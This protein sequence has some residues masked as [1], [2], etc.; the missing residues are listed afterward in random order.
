MSGQESNSD[1]TACISCI[2]GSTFRST[3]SQSNCQICPANSACVS[4]GF[5]C[6]SGYEP[7]GDGAGCVLCGEGFFKS[8]AGNSPC[9]QCSTGQESAANRESCIACGTGKYRPLS[10]FNKCIPCP[11]NGICNALSLTKCANGWKIISDGDGCEQCPVGQDSRDGLTCQ[12][13]PFGYFKPDQA[14]QTCIS[15]P[16]GSKSCFDSSVSCNVGYYYDFGAQCKINETYFALLQAG[17]TA[18]LHTLTVTKTV[19]TILPAVTVIKS[20]TKSQETVT[21]SFNNIVETVTLA[22]PAGSVALDYVG[23]LP[24]SPLLFGAVC[25]VGGS[26]ITFIITLVFCRKSPYRSKY[27]YFDG[28]HGTVTTDI[29]FSFCSIILV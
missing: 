4:T 27:E 14:Y 19:T 26:F 8:A 12:Q 13:C 16:Q 7:S 15:C 10:S 2:S 6:N 1:R 28:E 22:V 20:I 5:T 18:T 24:V 23:T 3:S 29:D 9:S 11:A 21:R 17:T 25:I